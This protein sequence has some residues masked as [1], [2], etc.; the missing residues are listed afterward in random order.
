MFVGNPSLNKEILQG[1]LDKAL[2]ASLTPGNYYLSDNCWLASQGD[3]GFPLVCF[4]VVM[5]EKMSSWC[6]SDVEPLFGLAKL[7]NHALPALSAKR[8]A[9]RFGFK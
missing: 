5:C 2:L 3:R 1:G 4:N 9:S 6:T 7:V 8:P